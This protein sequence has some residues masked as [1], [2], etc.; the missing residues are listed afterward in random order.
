MKTRLPTTQ[1][2]EELISFLPRLY[3]AGF[4]PIKRWGGGTKDENGVITIP[5]PEYEKIVE[6]FFRVA[7]RDFWIDYAYRS[8]D[9]GRMIENDDFIKAADLAQ[10][11]T[12]LTFCVR[13]E[14]FCDGHWG[15][16]IER[17]HI[18]R[19]LQRLAELRSKMA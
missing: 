6:E 14:R 13:G 4:T 3:A 17:G 16:M 11:K 10:V 12:M 5:W 8:E 2:I 1:E 7:S 9:A 19:L 18:R 15:A